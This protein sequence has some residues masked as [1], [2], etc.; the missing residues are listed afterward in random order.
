MGQSPRWLLSGCLNKISRGKLGRYTPIIS[1]FFSHA[2]PSLFGLSLMEF[3]STSSLSVTLF[4]LLSSSSLMVQSFNFKF[5]PARGL[6]HYFQ[7]EHQVYNAVKYVGEK[8]RRLRTRKPLHC[9]CLFKDLSMPNTTR[10]S[11]ANGTA[12]FS[13]TLDVSQLTLRIIYKYRFSR[14]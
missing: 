2:A 9:R 11:N 10:T 1:R 13:T 8:H 14:L 12:A 4:N 3:D 6:G 7:P 5:A